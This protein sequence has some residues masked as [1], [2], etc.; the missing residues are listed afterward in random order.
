MVEKISI[1]GIDFPLQARGIRAAIA[2]NLAYAKALQEA[3][4]FKGEARSIA[5]S[6]ADRIQGRI[7]ARAARLL[8]ARLNRGKIGVTANPQDF[9]LKEGSLLTK[10]LKDR[11]GSE[12]KA[13]VGGKG[14]KIGQITLNKDARELIYADDAGQARTTTVGEVK[15]QTGLTGDANIL[16]LA[17]ASGDL[18]S[19]GEGFD[20]TNFVFNSLFAKSPILRSLFYNKA[21]S[22]TFTQTYASKITYLTLAFPLQEFNSSNFKATIGRDKSIVLFVNDKFQ[23]EIIDKYNKSIEEDFRTSDF[24]DTITLSTGKKIDII[25]L[26]YNSTFT[27]G[28]EIE[29][30][31][32]T[33]PA[34]GGIRVKVTTPK[35]EKKETAQR[36]ISDAQMSALVQR[37]VE[38]RMPKGPLRGPP[39]S[40]TIL[41]YRTGQFVE[42]IKVIQDFRQS[43]MT[44]YYAPNYKIH[45]RK[46]ARAPRFLLQSSIR[47]T[48]QQ[49]YSEKFRIIRGF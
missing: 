38:K 44:Y 9:I 28:A 7:E 5:L 29:N 4:A 41:T 2:D 12:F 26:P 25:A 40:P 30:S 45:E 31:I 42:S 19:V 24:K 46:G 23:A 15:K 18:T 34:S 48:V 36:V 49:V 1:I 47:A 17:L 33:K 6:K 10:V 43:L 35:V 11:I 8:G 16:D 14:I 37:E 27:L 32:R 22:I 3:Q 39:L 21:S 13:S 20:I